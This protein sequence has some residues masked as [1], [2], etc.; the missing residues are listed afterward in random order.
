[1]PLSEDLE[2][3]FGSGLRKRHIAKFVD[4]QQFD[5]GELGLQFAHAVHRALPSID[6][7]AP[8]R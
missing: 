7:R 4:N 2:E 6:G 3:E 8:L 5:G 1:M